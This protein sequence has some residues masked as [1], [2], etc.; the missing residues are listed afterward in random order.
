LLAA[1]AIHGLTSV[2]IGLLYGAM[3]PMYPRKPILTAGFLAPFL[4]T[5]ILH[6]AIGVI[7][8]ILDQR[9]DWWWFVVS[10][11]AFGLVAGFVVNLQ[12]K[13]RTPQFRSLPFSVRAGL[14]TLGDEED[15]AP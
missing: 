6:S 5:G 15:K 7:S 4:W 10:Q 12:V 8:P 1:S 13:V 9:I 2:L 3:L 11:I 14:H